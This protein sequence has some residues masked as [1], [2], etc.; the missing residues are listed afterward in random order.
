MTGVRTKNGI[1][2]YVDGSYFVKHSL[3]AKITNM[4][5]ELDVQVIPD[6]SEVD[7]I[8]INGHRSQS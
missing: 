6:S 3:T 4:L 2:L 7:I 8:Y 1:I 5:N